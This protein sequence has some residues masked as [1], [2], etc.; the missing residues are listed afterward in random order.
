MKRK[1]WEIVKDRKAWFAAVH[2]LQRVGY[3]SATEEYPPLYANTMDI[4][5]LPLWFLP[6]CLEK[7]FNRPQE[8]LSGYLWN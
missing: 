2:G 5:K 1:L 3:G 8:K 6:H 4:E 7:G